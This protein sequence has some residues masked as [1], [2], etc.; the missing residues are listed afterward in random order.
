MV[1]SIAARDPGQTAPRPLL[2]APIRSSDRLVSPCQGEGREFES[3]IENCA[4]LRNYSDVA[5]QNPWSMHLYALV[6]RKQLTET[7]NYAQYV[8]MAAIDHKGLTKAMDLALVTPKQLAEAT[9]MSLTY[10]CDITAGRRTLKRNPELRKK[11]AVALNVPQ[12]WIEHAEP[13]AS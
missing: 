2:P 8:R 10:V 7:H 9:G 3:T 6:V 12:H 5:P 4:Q 13:V 11:I 1:T